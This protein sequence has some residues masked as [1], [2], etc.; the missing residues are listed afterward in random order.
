MLDGDLADLYEVEVKHLKRQVR[1]NSDRFP[2]DFLLK[3]SKEEYKALRSQLGTLKRGEHSKYLPYAFTEQGIAMLSSVLKSKRAILVNIAI[4]R[5]FVR[6]REILSS[7]K[8]LA[9]KLTA[10]ET[11]IEKHD[12]QIRSIFDAIRQL[13]ALPEKPTR[14]IGFLAEP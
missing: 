13:M 3:L 1:R 4:M 14:R 11:R 7:H 8:E 2:P 10:L 9:H 12:S 5:V 6:L